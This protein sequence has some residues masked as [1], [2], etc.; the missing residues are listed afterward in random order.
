MLREHVVLP[1]FLSLPLSED[2][3]PRTF[4]SWGSTLLHGIY[5]NPP[6]C[7]SRPRTT[8]MGFFS[9][10]THTGNESPR[11]TR[12]TGRLSDP[13]RR[14]NRP[15]PA[16]PTPPATAPLTGFFNLSATYSSQYPPVIFRQVAFMGFALQGFVPST[17]PLTIHHRQITLLPLLPPVAHLR[18]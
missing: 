1:V 8:L 2:A 15:L 3:T 12:F 6:S 10:S 16:G 14:L 18:S 17:K 9:P 7:V 13:T 5:L 4:L 11:P